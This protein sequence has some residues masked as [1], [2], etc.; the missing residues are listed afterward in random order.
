M[1][2]S[3]KMTFPIFDKIS[4]F[5]FVFVQGEFFDWSRLKSFK[6]QLVSKFWHLELFDG[7]YYVIWHLELFGR[8]QWKNSPCIWYT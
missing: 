7:I 5:V 8:D 2:Y 6:C 4:R 1:F 3:Y